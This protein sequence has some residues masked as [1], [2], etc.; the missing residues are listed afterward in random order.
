MADKESRNRKPKSDIEL[1][2]NQ[3]LCPCRKAGDQ[4][5]SKLNSKIQKRID[6]NLLEFNRMEE[7]SP[8]PCYKVT[9]APNKIIKITAKTS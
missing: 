7:T 9:I 5:A 8:N 6:N 4:M 2:N 3:K 1:D